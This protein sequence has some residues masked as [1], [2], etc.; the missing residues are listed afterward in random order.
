MCETDIRKLILDEPT[1]TVDSLPRGMWGAVV[2]DRSYTTLD[3]SLFAC[4]TNAT[5]EPATDASTESVTLAPSNE[6]TTS[7]SD[8]STESP[9]V[10][11]EIDDESFASQICVP[12][13]LFFAMM[14]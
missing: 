12:V 7:R 2:K 13:L 9:S 4:D 10:L 5:G 1:H 11:E 14:F 8:L 6:A 3:D